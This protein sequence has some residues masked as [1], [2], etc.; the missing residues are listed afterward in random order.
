M[1]YTFLDY[2]AHV[3]RRLI[4]PRGAGFKDFS[5]LA[6][7]LFPWDNL[8]ALHRILPRQS[9]VHAEHMLF[10][11]QRQAFCF[12]S[13]SVRLQGRNGARFVRCRPRDGFILLPNR[14]VRLI[15]AYPT[16]KEACESHDDVVWTRLCELLN[17]GH[18]LP[19]PLPAL[20]DVHLAATKA[21][22]G[23]VVEHIS[24]T[25]NF[26]LY[27]VIESLEVWDSEHA[28]FRARIL[29]SGHHGLVCLVRVP[30]DFVDPSFIRLS[31]IAQS[32][33][34]EWELQSLLRPVLSQPD[35]CLTPISS[36]SVALLP[37]RTR[38]H[39]TK[40]ESIPRE[41]LAPCPIIRFKQ[42]DGELQS[43]LNILCPPIM[44]TVHTV[45]KLDAV[46]QDDGVT[47]AASDAEEQSLVE[48][49]N[50]DSD[51]D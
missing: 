36:A 17:Y 19:G 22:S 26:H 48:T 2:A 1:G 4:K 35:F 12:R 7:Q 11:G 6:L 13:Y 18:A 14:V 15:L 29:G 45:T 24:H 20:W 37:A 46:I 25:T 3:F 23:R 42:P 21:T 49:L 5:Y 8:P 38:L 44:I 51:S 34:V 27:A 32:D 28:I 16:L 10:P 43:P 47:L 9:V 40:V 31:D 50:E 33:D 41:M 30:F 39:P